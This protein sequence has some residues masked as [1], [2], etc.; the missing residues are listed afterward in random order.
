MYKKYRETNPNMYQDWLTENDKGYANLLTEYAEIG[1][2][3]RLDK[4]PD[5]KKK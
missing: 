2:D 4:F 3:P 5:L 1:Q